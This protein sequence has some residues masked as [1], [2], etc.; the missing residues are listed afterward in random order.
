MKKPSREVIQHRKNKN[1]E[2][3]AR[4][5]ANKKEQASQREELIAQLTQTNTLLMRRVE[6]LTA[7]N[8]RLAMEVVNM[9]PSFETFLWAEEGV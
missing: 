3:A 1:K 2:S 8:D 4:S 9:Q 5:R 7:T 6:E